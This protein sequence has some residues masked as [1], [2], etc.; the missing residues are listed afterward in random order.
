MK[1]QM[2]TLTEIYEFL[3]VE[4]GVEVSRLKED[5]DLLKDFG[6]D[7]DDFFELMD[8]FEKE[9]VVDLS[10][11][12]WYF[13]HYDEGSLLSVTRA[14]FETKLEFVPITPAILLECVN[15]GEWPL[16]YPEGLSRKQL[17]DYLVIFCD[18]FL[19]PILLGLVLAG[20]SLFIK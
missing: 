8:A 15:T 19:L 9:Y 5:S 18:W 20:V 13:H 1:I 16:H 11:Y 3:S 6:V 17:P 7:G 10:G 2:A 14:L 4:I 12:I